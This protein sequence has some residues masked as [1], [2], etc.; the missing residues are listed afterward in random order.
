MIVDEHD[1]LVLMDSL[2]V[3]DKIITISSICML[4][5]TS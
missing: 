5:S 2:L 4:V 1:A 3:D